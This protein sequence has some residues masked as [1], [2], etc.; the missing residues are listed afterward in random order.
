M[1]SETS[2]DYD[3]KH[4]SLEA[5]LKIIQTDLKWKR[6]KY[7]Q[8]SRRFG[9]YCISNTPNVD[10]AYERNIYFSHLNQFAKYPV[11][12]IDGINAVG[13]STITKH[14]NR[15]YCK[16][17]LLHPEITKG[18][19]YNLYP[20]HAIEYIVSQLKPTNEPTVWDRDRYSNL[21]FYYVHY[22]C[23]QFR[24]EVLDYSEKCALRVYEKINALAQCLH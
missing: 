24:D 1:A 6:F 10:M 4:L 9:N 17:N 20:L 16:I 2:T 21:R 13:K 12:A 18:Q 5:K 8:N 14:I 7:I 11:I 22:L 15:S 19:D 23:Y 3:R